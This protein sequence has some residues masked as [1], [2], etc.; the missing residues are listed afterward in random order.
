[1]SLSTSNSTRSVYKRPKK[2]LL[3]TLL[4]CPTLND[5]KLHSIHSKFLWS[6]DSPRKDAK[7]QARLRGVKFFYALDVKLCQN[8]YKYLKCLRS[9]KPCCKYLILKFEKPDL[10]IKQFPERKHHLK[11][12]KLVI[13]SKTHLHLQTKFWTQIAPKITALDYVSNEIA[14]FRQV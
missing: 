10:K 4:T 11:E 2:S 14:N 6:F 7:K 8:E 5:S 12:F 1:M 9:D 13:N 3:P